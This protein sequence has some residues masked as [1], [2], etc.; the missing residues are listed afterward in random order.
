MIEEIALRK[1][2]I[3][4]YI[5][6]A[7]FEELYSKPQ[8]REEAGISR[9]TVKDIADKVALIQAGDFPIVEVVNNE[10]RLT[11]IDSIETVTAYAYCGQNLIPTRVIN[12][13]NQDFPAYLRLCN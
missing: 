8:V 13:D 1:F 7:W 6:P 11:I 10:G 4:Q 12:K 9:E 3:E 5:S 2:D